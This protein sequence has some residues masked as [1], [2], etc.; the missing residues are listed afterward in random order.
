[1][2]K[3]LIFLLLP[4]QLLAQR[5]TTQEIQR[6][7][8]QAK[9]VTII[10][11]TWGIPHIY[12]K[13][14]ANAVF[15]LLYA[16]CEDDFKRVEM[17]YIEKLGR[18]SEIK[19]KTEL[20][21]DLQIRLLIDSTEAIADYKKAEPWMKKLLNAY[22]DGINY[23]LATHPDTK[24]LL[25]NRF[26]PWYPLLWTDGSI[27][28][29]S[30]ADISNAELK[31]FYSGD[32]I[33][34]IAEPKNPELQTGSNG[35]AFAPTI[36]ASK[37]AILY[38]NPHVTFYFRPEVHMVS[39][40]GLNAYGAV[41]W[42]QFFVYQGFNPYCGWMH[43]SSNVDVADMYAEKII[44]KDNRLFYVYDK[45]LLPVTEKQIALNYRQGDSLKTRDFTTYY[46]HHGPVMAK[47]DGQWISLKS[48]NRS[49][50]SLVQS[51]KRTKAKGFE[52]YKKV[53]DLKANTSNNTVFADNKGNI[54]YWHGNYIPVRDRKLNWAKVI[55]G[56]TSATEWK[57][58]H[59]VDEIVHVYNPSNGWLQNCNSTP[60]TV[61]GTQ[62][63]KK[64]DYPPYMAPDGENFRG[65][66]AVRVLS[67]QQNY[68]LDY[69]I[70]AGYDNYL[71]AFEVLIPALITVFEREVK[72]NDSLHS[73]LSEPIKTLKNW[74]YRATETSIATTLA[75]EWAQKLSPVLQKLYIDEGET[76]QVENTKRF[77]QQATSAQLI[78]PLATVIKELT[79]KFGTWQKPWGDLN[80]SQRLTGDIQHKYD[81][82]Q[83]SL[84]VGYASALWGMLPSYNSRYYPNTLKRYGVS[85]NSFVCAVE[86]GKKIKAKSLLAGG[87]SG[88]PSSKHFN[89]QAKM[90]TKGIFKEVL[91]YKEDVEKQAEKRYHPGQ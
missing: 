21:N 19:G 23:Y 53:M 78:T 42:G 22:A 77:A 88:N 29:I 43:T 5:F 81:D 51:W 57:G 73:V 64:N 71:A 4:L 6:Y 32:K 82:T 44:T 75:I 58:L 20:F 59:K 68:T 31:N 56:S 62:S 41:T 28:A 87:E 18:L 26:Q 17:N 35:F 80:R 24:P 45:Q 48:F 79:T 52:A 11:D 63:P 84:P 16:Q 36:T 1:M 46:T 86:F 85:G 89:D 13:T 66:N 39:E 76:D 15:G 91:F 34:A 2:K 10:R 12:G 50:I 54:A 74:D 40:E 8:Q 38:I 33:A 25:L 65:I 72:T 70:K 37:N 49:M 30:T 3:T 14:D 27:G 90:Y 55:D 69:V 83:A 7:Q 60:F 61:A 47:R 9:Q 67:S